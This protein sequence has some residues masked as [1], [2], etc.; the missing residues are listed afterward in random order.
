MKNR[1]VYVLISL[2][3]SAVLLAVLFSQ[4][5]AEDFGRILAG[6]YVP[7]LLAYVA[8]NLAAAAVRAWR[9]KILLAPARIGWG[10]MLLVT[11]I[12]NSFVDLLPA[13]IGSLSY[14]YVLNKR[15][16]FSFESAASTFV[17]AMVFDFLTLSPFILV[18]LLAVGGSAQ[19]LPFLSLLAAAGAFFVLFGLIVWKLVPLSR[20]ALRALSAVL[21][22]LGW[23]DRPK[24]RTAGL[25]IGAT[26]DSLETI[27]RRGIA[28]RLFGLSLLIR[29]G[30]YLSLFA[31]LHALLRSQ[32]FG[33]FDLSFGKIIL[34]VTGAE[35]T[36]LLPVKGLAGFG[37]WESAWAVAFRL[38]G[39]DPRFAVLTGIGVHLVSNLFE[40]SL[41]LAALLI[42]VVPYL[43][44]RRKATSASRS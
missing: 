17:V 6:I 36:S 24:A 15:L 34:G 2:A 39:Y 29:A 22:L 5:R 32:G 31:L 42:L 11:F 37:T 8:V 3:V 13:R 40:Y 20:L 33:L 30:K 14:V 23:A 9:Y 27:R 7:A 44:R 25:K 43:R 28:G 19:G 41:G 35:L 38:M 18:S 1:L 12:R 26:I 4:V 16:G 10:N 21:R